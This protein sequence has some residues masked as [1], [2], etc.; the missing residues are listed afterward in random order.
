MTKNDELLLA[1]GEGLGCDG[2]SRTPSILPPSRKRASGTSWRVA[3]DS[4]SWKELCKIAT[5]RVRFLVFVFS[6]MSSVTCP[7]SYPTN[8][9][10]ERRSC[11]SEC[12]GETSRNLHLFYTPLLLNGMD[13]PWIQGNVLSSRFIDR[14]PGKNNCMKK[15]IS[16]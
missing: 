8:L 15:K 10:G 4:T 5:W 9:A 7:A 14:Y 13:Y 1:W 11:H 2:N 16:S 3:D 12:G 6:V